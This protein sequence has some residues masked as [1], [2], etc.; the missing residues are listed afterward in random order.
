MRKLLSFQKDRQGS[1]A[2]EFGLILLMFMTLCMGVV[3][4]MRIGFFLSDMEAAMSITSRWIM[5]NPTSTMTQIK[6]YVTNQSSIL[7]LGDATYTASLTTMNGKTYVELDGR[8]T[9][10]NVTGLFSSLDK[11]LTLQMVIPS[12]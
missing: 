9:Y 10:H 4:F 3:E 1:M 11:D 5:L 12:Y 6:T 8:Y 7:G 2:L